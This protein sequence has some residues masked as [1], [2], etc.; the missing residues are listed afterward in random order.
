MRAE[1][2][3]RMATFVSAMQSPLPSTPFSLKGDD[4]AASKART[5][6]DVGGPCDILAA[7]GHPCVAAHSTVRALYAAYTGPLYNL[8]RPGGASAQVGVRSGFADI[9][10]HERFC[11]ADDCVISK[12]FDQSGHSNDLTGRFFHGVKNG[13]SLVPASKH[14]ISVRG[15]RHAY[16][17]WFDPGHVRVMQPCILCPLSQSR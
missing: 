10:V 2:L 5:R 8:S 14:K 9:A 11:A 4:L 16:A 13:S 17:M 3:A 6:A 7:A 1:N 12:V 15:G